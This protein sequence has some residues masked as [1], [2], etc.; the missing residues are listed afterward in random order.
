MK[1]TPP[2]AITTRD[3]AT[4]TT[5]V[6]QTPLQQDNQTQKA[7]AS[8]AKASNTAHT[9]IKPTTTPNGNLSGTTQPTATSPT[10]NRKTNTISRSQRTIT[11]TRASHE[12]PNCTPPQFRDAVN[13]ALKN[14]GAPA[15]A[16]IS[17][18]NLNQNNNIVL[19][20]RED[21]TA[22]TILAYKDLID[23]TAHQLDSSVVC[24]KPQEVWSKVAIHG[25]NLEAF[26]DTAQGMQLLQE[27]IET[28]NPTITL[29]TLPRYL[30]RPE[31]RINKRDSSVCV[32]VN[33]ETL[34]RQMTKQGVLI[35][36][37][38]RKT[39]RY[40]TARPSD[41]CTNCQGFGHHW[42]RCRLA[43]RC[44]LC[45]QQHKTTEHTCPTCPRANGKQCPHTT[46]RCNNCDGPHHAS[47][48]SCEL[49]ISVRSRRALYHRE[50][51][52]TM[53]EEPE[54]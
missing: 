4:E 19:L 46:L 10:T 17:S 33:S 6:E 15:N 28:H 29:T 38:R 40:W 48:R 7:P 49:L 51:D 39:E 37:Q 16:L 21:C 26:P 24:I 5:P 11:I 3:T 54:L 50:E 12:K 20:T 43:A 35:L 30:T 44:R 36:C 23:R 42:R 32:C 31:N 18:V 34:A 1:T 27:E 41:Q 13:T 52:A 22:N 2:A 25:I 14:A 9:P 47:D 45:A 53:T 8:Y